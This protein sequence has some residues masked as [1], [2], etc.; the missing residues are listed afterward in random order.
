MLIMDMIIIND[1]VFDEKAKEALEIHLSITK[2][3]SSQMG[4]SEKY[5]NTAVRT[6]EGQINVY[7]AILKGLLTGGI[8]DGE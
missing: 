7:T 6:I 2:S 5:Q 1:K 4:M 8:K 3:I